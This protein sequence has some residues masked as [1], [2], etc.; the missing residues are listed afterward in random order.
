MNKPKELKLMSLRL[1]YV[2]I[3]T[4]VKF[5]QGKVLTVIDASFPSNEQRKAVKDLINKS[6]SEQLNYLFQLTHPEA[7]VLSETAMDSLI[8]PEDEN[9]TENVKVVDVPFDSTYK[10]HPV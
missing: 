8:I 9:E 5:L 10:N 6:F 7:I 2:E 3:E 1:E 4:Q